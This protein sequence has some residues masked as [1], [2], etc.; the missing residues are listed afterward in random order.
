MTDSV[1]LHTDGSCLRNPGPGGWAAVLQWRDEIREL[2]GA[3]A[4]S[5]NNRMELQAAIEGLNAL[6]RPM[7][8]DL[9]T[10]S[11]Y[12]MQG[13]ESWMPRWKLNG[14]RTAA[15]KPVLNQDLWQELDA[16]LRRHQVTW[17]WVKGHA[18]NEMNERCDELARAAATALAG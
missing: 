18:G 11:K 17:H 15:K 8:V 3:V 10:D 7:A 4:D 5:T 1:T 9:H 16:A 6:K 12:V 14:W 13:V 2:S